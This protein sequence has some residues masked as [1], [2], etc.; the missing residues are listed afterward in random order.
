M[1]HSLKYSPFFYFLTSA[2]PSIFFRTIY[3]IFVCQILLECCS[4][5]KTFLIKKNYKT[6]GTSIKNFFV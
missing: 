6:C 2:F 1:P 3:F 4:L 5:L